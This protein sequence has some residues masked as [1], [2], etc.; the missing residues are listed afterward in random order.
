MNRRSFLIV[1]P[2]LVMSLGTLRPVAAAS[3]TAPSAAGLSVNLHNIIKSVSVVDGQ[4]VATTIQGQQVPLTPSPAP[5]TSGTCSILN[6]HLGP[7]NLNLLGLQVTTSPI[8]LTI[9]GQ[10]NGGL[11]GDLLCRLANALN[12]TGG[13]SSFLSGLSAP[14]L[15]TLTTGLTDLLNAVLNNLNQAVVTAI[16]PAQG[17]ACPILTLSLGPLHL[18]LLGLV[19][20]LNNCANPAGPVTVNVT[21]IPGGGLLGNLLC[22]LLGNVS[23]GTTLQAL[24]QQILQAI[25]AFPGL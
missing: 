13:L 4:L 25:M 1:I 6:L 18:T 19:V 16:Q 8:C 9:T 24:L 22:Q 5:P 10:Q 15:A 17:G 12:N 20:D 21:A 3:P 11:L 2:A 7:I 23:L 14:D